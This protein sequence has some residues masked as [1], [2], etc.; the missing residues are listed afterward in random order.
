MVRIVGSHHFAHSGQIVPVMYPHMKKHRRDLRAPVTPLGTRDNLPSDNFNHNNETTSNIPKLA[1]LSPSVIDV[2][3]AETAVQALRVKPST[4]G[5]ERLRSSSQGAGEEDVVM[6][7]YP[8]HH[9]HRG[10]EGT[11]L[12]STDDLQRRLTC[13][14][15]ESDAEETQQVSLFISLPFKNHS[16]LTDR[17]S[18]NWLLVILYITVASIIL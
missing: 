1:I 18:I 15:T 17:Q 10:S 12:D 14:W 16:V 6:C 7:D 5:V 13:D 8:D 11:R 9:T 3:A 2:R 4:S